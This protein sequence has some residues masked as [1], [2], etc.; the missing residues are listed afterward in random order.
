MHLK[1]NGAEEM[2]K[3]W[4]IKRNKKERQ[5]EGEG[6]EGARG[7]KRERETKSIVNHGFITIFKMIKKVT[8]ICCIFIIYCIYF[9]TCL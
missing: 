3:E 9:F 2:I 8:H 5:K 7:E 1:Y 4:K 6:K